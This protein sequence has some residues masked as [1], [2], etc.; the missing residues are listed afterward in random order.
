MMKGLGWV[1]FGISEEGDA[2][3][4]E[5]RN[6]GRISLGIYDATDGDGNTMT[7]FAMRMAM[8]MIDRIN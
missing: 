3:R 4:K 2:W 7:N 5:D 6:A 8:S 1:H